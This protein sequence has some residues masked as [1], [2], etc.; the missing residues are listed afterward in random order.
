MKEEQSNQL[1]LLQLGDYNARQ[2]PVNT[3]RQQTGQ[4]TKKNLGASNHKATEITNKPGT[5]ISVEIYYS[6]R[7]N[8][9]LRLRRYLFY[10]TKVIVINR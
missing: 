3:T 7:I 8:W 4:N 9:H 1:C 6:P 5:Q 2:D 10:Q